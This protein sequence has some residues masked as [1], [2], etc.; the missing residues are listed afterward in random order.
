MPNAR[1]WAFESE[2]TDFGAVVPDRRDLGK[3]VVIDFMLIHGNGW[4]VMPFDLPVG[5][6]CRLDTFLVHDVFGVLTLVESANTGGVPLVGL[7]A[8]A[9]A[10]VGAGI[11]IISTSIRRDP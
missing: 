7:A 8:V 1:W 6:V 2:A 10:F 5:S 4:F 9:L 3:L 11:S